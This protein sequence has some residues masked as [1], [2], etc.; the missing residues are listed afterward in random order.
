M[1]REQWKDLGEKTKARKIQG[2]LRSQWGKAWCVDSG[3]D[4]TDEA[5]RKALDDGVMS[6]QVSVVQCIDYDAK[7]VQQLVK[8]Q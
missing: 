3:V 5:M 7:L 8:A 6:W 1:S 4:P 2:T